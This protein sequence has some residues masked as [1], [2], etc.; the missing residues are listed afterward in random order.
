MFWKDCAGRPHHQHASTP[1]PS[2]GPC[3]YKLS[4]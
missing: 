3:K 1:S 2:R 4:L